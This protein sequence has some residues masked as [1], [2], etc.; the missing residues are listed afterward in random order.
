[1]KYLLAAMLL[2][3]GAAPALAFS[4][5]MT[6]VNRPYELVTIGEQVIQT[7]DYLGELTGFPVMYEIT[8]DESFTL[9]AQVK[10]RYQSG[11]EPLAFSVIVIKQD[12][13]GG[14]VTEVARLRPESADWQ[15][16]KDPQLGF[17]LWAGEVLATAVEPGTYRIEVSTP[18]N[19]GKYLL[20]FGTAETDDGY[21]KSL[22]GV[23][24]TQEF[25]G[26]TFFQLLASSL[27]YYPLGL[28]LLGVLLQRIWK[29]RKIVTEYDT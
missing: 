24:R 18:E 19:L 5:V 16:L 13:R 27:V 14:G 20:S 9:Q 17:R 25:F 26:L 10:Q 7:Q 23:R 12:A 15:L 4:P 21:F 2:L 29:Y 11:L 22:A 28:L 3:V 6:E 1:M 8:S